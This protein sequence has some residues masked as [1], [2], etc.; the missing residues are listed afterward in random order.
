[1]A[2]EGLILTPKD[3][4]GNTITIQFY[5]SVYPSLPISLSLGSEPI[6]RYDSEGDDFIAPIRRI[7]CEL[8]L[9]TTDFDFLLQILDENLTCEIFIGSTFAFY[10]YYFGDGVEYDETD[11]VKNVKVTFVDL[12]GRIKNKKFEELFSG[13]TLPHVYDLL[14][15]GNTRWGFRYHVLQHILKKVCSFG[16]RGVEIVGSDSVYDYNGTKL[17][18]YYDDTNY[19]DK[20]MLAGAYVDV[21]RVMGKTYYDILKE[22]CEAFG[23]YAVVS[24]K[25]LI[26]VHINSLIGQGSISQVHLSYNGTDLLYSGVDTIS[27][28]PKII[29]TVE[30]V[31]LMTRGIKNVKVKSDYGLRLDKHLTY[32]KI[33][34]ASSFTA[35][36]SQLAAKQS[37]GLIKYS[38]VQFGTINVNGDI[39]NFYNSGYSSALNWMQKYMRIPLWICNI[40][41]T[42][43]T[44]A[45]VTLKVEVAGYHA[46][47]F[48]RYI[49]VILCD[50]QYF[51]ETGDNGNDC[52]GPSPSTEKH[53]IRR[54][55]DVFTY[56]R[57]SLAPNET[58]WDVEFNIYLPPSIDRG[59]NLMVAIPYYEYALQYFWENV[60]VKDIKMEIIPEKGF[61]TGETVE[62]INKETLSATLE[63]EL[64]YGSCAR[65]ADDYLVFDP[66]NVYRGSLAYGTYSGGMTVA[67]FFGDDTEKYKL[68]EYIGRQIA[69]QNDRINY[70]AKIVTRERLTDKIDTLGYFSLFNA[71]YRYG[72]KLFMP[73]SGTYMPISQK[74]EITA[75]SINTNTKLITEDAL[76]VIITE[77]GLNIITD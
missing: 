41:Y 12:L 57:K 36:K 58:S 74:G 45:K 22:I 48:T 26:L 3:Y 21:D 1:M 6:F 52:W 10:G 32:E 16:F 35:F 53:A 72:L 20:N 24:Y 14:R 19:S 5:H 69:A 2:I 60:S 31:D 27:V 33:K 56:Y 46:S 34:E 65:T 17:Y 67:Q 30:G 55:G 43:Q 9:V 25:T 39:I 76:F 42:Q 64:M 4:E 61:D 44:T 28:V 51:D 54:T 37:T 13:I 47:D 49:S 15:G 75:V 66:H 63:K 23:Y 7:S 18:G 71:I 40:P 73:L 50:N 38:S 11:E 29:G 8:Q 62:V 59:V 68:N 70:K 77:D